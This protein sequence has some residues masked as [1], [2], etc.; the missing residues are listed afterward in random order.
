MRVVEA[1][2]GIV[3]A[4]PP[5]KFDQALVVVDGADDLIVDRDR[6]TAGRCEAVDD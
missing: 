5:E 3:E 6:P 2:L 4:S 1:M